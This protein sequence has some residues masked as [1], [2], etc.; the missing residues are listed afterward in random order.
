MRNL[1][2]WAHPELVRD[3]PRR[4]SSSGRT[5]TRQFFFVRLVLYFAIWIGIAFPLSRLSLRQDRGGDT[6]CS[7]ACGWSRRPG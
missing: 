6:A 1:Y 4:C 5:S 3:R 2:E 7:A